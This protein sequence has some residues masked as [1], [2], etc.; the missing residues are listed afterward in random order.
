MARRLWCTG[1]GRRGGPLV[2]LLLVVT[3]LSACQG[4]YE[5]SAT[6]DGSSLSAVACPTSSECLAVGSDASG[7]AVVR[8]T[9]DAGGQWVADTRGVSGLGLSAVSCPDAEHCVAVGGVSEGGIIAPS[10]AVLVTTDGGTTWKASTVPSADGYLTSVSCPAVGHCWATAAVGIVGQSTVIAT[11]NDATSWSTLPWSAPPFPGGRTG[12]IS[13]QLNVITCPTTEVCVAV[14]Q[15]SSTDTSAIPPEETEG[16]VATTKDGGQTWQSHLVATANDLTGLSCPS[17]DDCVAA[18][19]D[20]VVAGQPTTF[21]AYHVVTTD[22]GASWTVSTLAGGSQFAGGHAPAVNALACADTSHCVVVGT[23][24][25]TDKYRT[26][27]VATSDGGVTWSTQATPVPSGAPLDGVACV[28]PTSC[29][30][31]GFTSAGAVIV[32]TV[33]G[34]VALPSVS[35]VT[36]DAGAQAGATA[37]TITGSGLGDGTPTVRFGTVRATEVTVVSGSEITA[38]AP[39]SSG[40]A[41]TVDV[42]VTN[43]LGTSPVNPGD[44][45]TYQSTSAA[46]AA[47]PSAT[48]EQL[49]RAWLQ[50]TRH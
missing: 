7:N 26:A 42:T 47:T 38:L 46:D 24:F 14:G 10:N 13:S 5:Q 34:G 44:R 17:V 23:V 39:A 31:D 11:T 19:E 2:V 6:T 48:V 1:L 32:H 18:G 28:S 50:S 36:P 15:A 25:G 43:P 27:V 4:W 20:T 35:S 30:A 21:S 22:A 45:Y 3:A 29:W 37:V 16:V 40:G 33:T 12:P 41:T 8:Q 9:T 49:L